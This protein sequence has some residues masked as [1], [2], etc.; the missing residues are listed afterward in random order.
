M[1]PDLSVLSKSLKITNKW[2]LSLTGNSLSHVPGGSLTG[3]SPYNV[4]TTYLYLDLSKNRISKIENNAFLG[5]EN[6]KIEMDLSENNLTEVPFAFLMLNQLG[7]ISLEFNPIKI[8][9]PVILHH[10][11]PMVTYIE[12]GIGNMS[13]WPTA[14]SSFTVLE[15]AWLYEV[16]QYKLP[17]RPFY[18]KAMRIIT[19]YGSDL[20]ML[21]CSLTDLNELHEL[22]LKRSPNL[23]ATNLVEE[24]RPNYTMSSTVERLHLVRGELTEFPNILKYTPMLTV[25]NLYRNK[26]QQVNEAFIPVNNLLTDLMLSY[27]QLQTIPNSFLRFQHLKKFIIDNNNI[28][29]VQPALERIMLQYP[30]SSLCLRDNPV[31]TTNLTVKC[32]SSRDSWAFN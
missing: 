19:I 30:F 6:I 10:F 26:I 7:G 21:P 29:T 25:L 3:F 14:L 9:D 1:F 17:Q 24:C 8:I 12:L 2:L 20:A 13:S 11:A 28:A 23:N 18:E 15:S 4:N 22:T 32:S 27:N 31:D 16:Q 5:I